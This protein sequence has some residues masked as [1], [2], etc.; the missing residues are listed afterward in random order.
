MKERNRNIL[1]SLALFLGLACVAGNGHALQPAGYPERPIRLVV[2]SSGGASDLLARLIGSHLSEALGQQVVV[3][4]R[5]GGSG[6]VAAQIVSRAAPD[7]YTLLLTFHAH[8]LN[9][10]SGV[11]LPYDALKDFSPITQL[12]SSGSLLVIRAS[13]PIRS[14]PEFINWTRSTKANLNVGVPGLDSGGYLAATLYNQMAG[15]H[16]VLINHAGSAPALIGVVGNQYDYAFTSV[17]A[18]M[19]FVRNGQLR[20]IGVTTPKRLKALP[21]IPAMAEA[22]PGFAVTGW[23]GMLAPARVP[24]PVIDK[25][26]SEI[27]KALD[28]PRLGQAIEADGAEIVG[29]TPSDFG[30]FLERDVQKWKKVLGTTRV[31]VK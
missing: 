11:K 6:V 19:G 7:G 31:G 8:T 3:D 25:L 29:S 30:V 10:A 9:V 26:H 23:W 18:A 15:A 20:A 13:A 12:I 27:V 24:Q 28:T 2:V 17:I 14:L 21:D 4:P 5:P 16:A 22:L 1:A